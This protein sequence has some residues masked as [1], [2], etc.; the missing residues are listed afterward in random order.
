MDD[1]AQG[2]VGTHLRLPSG[3]VRGSN[4]FGLFCVE[5]RYFTY[6]LKFICFTYRIIKISKSVN[7]GASTLGKQSAP[8][9]TSY[10]PIRLSM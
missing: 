3:R 9:C 7:N 1:V 10:L 2:A 6:E 8:R 5:V 4:L